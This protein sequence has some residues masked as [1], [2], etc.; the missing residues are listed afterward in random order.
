VQRSRTE[1]GRG[2]PFSEN[3]DTSS[4]KP[5]ENSGRRKPKVSWED[6]P[7]PGNL[8]FT[9]TRILIWFI[10]TRVCIL[11]ERRSTSPFGSASLHRSRSPTTAEWRTTLLS[12]ASVRYLSP[13]I[14]GAK[15]LD[16][17][18]ITHC[19]NDGCL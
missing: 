2:A 4:D 19:L 6:E 13:I 14:F 1:R 12:A 15:S 18:A 17:S 5:D 10:A 9:A 11:T 16:E 3:A 7:G 8:G